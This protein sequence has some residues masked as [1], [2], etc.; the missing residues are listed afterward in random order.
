MTR[1]V[2]VTILGHREIIPKAG[3]RSS[4]PPARPREPGKVRAGAGAEAEWTWEPP[5]ESPDE[6]GP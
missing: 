4:K 3:N 1:L 5:T 6:R 2:A